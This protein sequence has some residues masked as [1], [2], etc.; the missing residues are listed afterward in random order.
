MSMSTK[1]KFKKLKLALTLGGNSSEREIS[2]ASGQQIYQYLN[3][4]KYSVKI[5]D[6]KFDL[7]DLFQDGKLKKFDVAFLSL[8]GKLGED[9]TIQ[10]L[11]EM[12]KVPYTGS[13][14]LASALAINKIISKKIFKSH[15][16]STPPFIYF[17]KY[18]YQKIKD[19]IFQKMK[20]P[21]IVK[22][23]DSGSSIGVT[24]VKKES[25]IKVALRNAFKESNEIIIE[26]FI[27]GLE[28]SVP[29]L[30][31][32]T[33]PIIEIIPK[34]GTG[35]F[36]YKA[37]YTPGFCEEIVPARISATLTRKIQNLAFKA[38]ESLFCYNY[39]RIDLI[40]DKK[41]IPWILEVNTL[42]GMTQN[43]LL[44]KSAKAAGIEFPELLDQIIKLAM[45]K[46]FKKPL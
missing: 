17:S 44:P 12:L 11:L 26:K 24:L 28:L 25:Q 27:N 16:I 39:S 14:V 9:G 30:G 45:N 19:K 41:N 3:R 23:A 5:Y 4:K 6:P 22:P 15:N 20:L 43:S 38:H 1:N 36:D 33:L 34:T 13:G 31:N 21:F 32:R 18:Q 8:H 29:V 46:N 35:L 7:A 37:K 2:L 10:G 40:L 42:P